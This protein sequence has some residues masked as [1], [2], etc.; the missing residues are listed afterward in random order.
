M[1]RSITE[2]NLTFTFPDNWRISKFDDSSFYRNQFQ[3]VCGGAKA[4]DLLVVNPCTCLWKIE[5]KDYR[6]HRRT[7]TI[8]LAVEIAEKVR[9]SL[10]ALVAA[11]V[12]ANDAA[13]KDMAKSTLECPELRVVLHLEQPAKHST[14][15]P[16]AIDPALVKQE[17]KRLLKPIDPHPIVTQMG[18]MQNVVWTVKSNG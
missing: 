8:A 18:R 3:N 1:T 17:L 6:Q 4:V 15:F 10:A 5:V 12:N 14:L 16:R 9:D 13:E 7:K 11:R 2:G